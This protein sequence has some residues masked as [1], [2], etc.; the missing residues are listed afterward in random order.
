MKIRN[1]IRVLLLTALCFLPLTLS[2][3]TMVLIPGFQ[4]QGMD[5]RSTQV[6]TALEERGWVDGGNFTLTR[7]GIVNPVKLKSAPKK[8]FYSLDLVTEAPI[9][10]QARMLQK[11]LEVIYAD[12]KEPLAL[13]GHSAGGIVA[14][15][16]LVTGNRLPVDT[17]ITIASPHL[18]TPLAGLSSIL[19]G[20]EE[21][22]NLAEALGFGNLPKARGLFNDLREEKPG[23]YLFWL[24]RQAHPAIRYVSVVRSSEQPDTADIVVPVPSQDM[25][26]VFALR[27]RTERWDTEKGHFLGADDGYLLDWVMAQMKL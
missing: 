18:G 12:R 19:S 26:N 6:A 13:V 23:T 15:H 2:A 3:Q 20:S 27:K 14:R 17:L 25:D 21:I 8:V 11:Y 1:F 10:D 9:A 5:W 22:V 4:S 24:N 16:W 7:K